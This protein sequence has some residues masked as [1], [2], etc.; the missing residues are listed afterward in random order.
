MAKSYDPH[1][2]SQLFAV[3]DRHFWFRARNQLV[4][5]IV[6][7]L[8]ATLPS[9]M[10]AIEVGCGTGN[11]LRH[12]ERVLPN[13]FIIGMDSFFTG[14]RYAK[15]RVQCQ[16]VEGDM[17][18]PPFGKQFHFV[19]MFDVLEHLPDDRQVL[20]DLHNMLTPNG[21]LLLTVPAH[22]SLWSY[23]DESAYHVRRYGVVELRDKLQAAGYVVEF[24]SQYMMSTYP[25]LWLRRKFIG[26]NHTSGNSAEAHV[27]A[28]Q[29]L[30]I[31]PVL[32]ELLTAI[33]SLEAGWISQGRRLP[34]GT[35][36]IAVARKPPQ[37]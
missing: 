37:G 15:Q 23:F 32:N 26:R 19:G 29:E 33:L 35:S 2:F 24:I 1:W 13:S 28:K 31:V 14:L 25:L 3:E 17:H 20:S 8:A 27:L 18:H 30:T 6:K 36:L 4:A 21:V 11:V 22:L 7:R 34:F 10:C 12:L 9:E 5:S 16:L